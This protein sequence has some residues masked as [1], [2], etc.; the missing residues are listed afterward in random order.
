MSPETAMYV[1][2]KLSRGYDP[3]SD[4]RFSDDLQQKVLGKELLQALFVANG[5]PKKCNI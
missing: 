5:V 4:E 1:L 2:Y 3:E